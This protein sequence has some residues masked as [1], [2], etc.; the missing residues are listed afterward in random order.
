M[1]AVILICLLFVAS[2]VNCNVI[3]LTI[4]DFQERLP[5]YEKAIVAFTA[6]WNWY[7]KQLLPEFERASREGQTLTP[8]VSYINIDCTPDTSPCMKAGVRGF[9]SVKFYKSGQ[10][11]GDFNGPRQ[12]ILI[13]SFAGSQ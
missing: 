13:L 6:S 12:A 10:Y 11:T 8:H 2:T 7:C 1:N 3:N 5:Q 4:Y 9:P